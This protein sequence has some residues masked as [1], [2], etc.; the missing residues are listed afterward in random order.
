[1]G[2][3]IIGIDC[4]V[5]TGFAVGVKGQKQLLRVESMTITQAMQEVINLKNP[6]LVVF[7]E[8]AR[9][10]TWFTGGKEKAQGAGSIKRDCG[11]WEQFC[12][13]QAIQYQLIHPACNNT[14]LKAV[15]FK[16][17]T[18]W[19]GVTNEHARDAAMLI[20]GR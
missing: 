4:G 5:K 7:I 11:I 2:Q 8:D 18:G 13:E 12:K 1:M 14:K 3:I 10:R 15:D 20:Y 19:Q 17:I 16:R 9:Q 6:D